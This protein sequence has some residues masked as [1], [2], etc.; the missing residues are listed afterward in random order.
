MGFTLES[1][2]SEILASILAS[3]MLRETFFKYKDR[4]NELFDKLRE[5]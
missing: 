2:N 4:I 1:L 3:Y 5:E